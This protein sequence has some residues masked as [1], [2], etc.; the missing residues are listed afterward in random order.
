MFL[1]NIN[2]LAIYLLVLVTLTIKN[3]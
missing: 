3:F 2:D 1:I